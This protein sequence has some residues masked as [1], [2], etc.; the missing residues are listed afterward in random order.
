ML[1]LGGSL[2]EVKFVWEAGRF[3]QAYTMARAAALDPGA[4]PVLAS[5]FYSQVDDFMGRN[6]LGFGLHWASGQEVALRVLAWLFGLHVFSAFGPVPDSLS[7]AIGRHVA[8]SAAHI[9]GHIE[10][11]R[12]AVYNNHLL[13]EAL[14]LYAAGSLLRGSAAQRWRDTGF[15]ILVEQADRQVYADGASIQAS[16]NYQRVAMQLYAWATAFRR[17]GGEPVPREWT[18]AMERSLDFLVA[19]QNPDD[20]RLPNYGSNDGSNPIALASTDF[21]DFRPILQTLSVATRGERIYEAGAWDEM[22]AWLFG[23]E[24]LN[25]P[26]RIPNRTSV[27]FAATGYHVLRGKEP[28]SFCTFRCG[29]IRDRFSQIDMLHLDVWWRGENVL[30]D[31]GSYLYNGPRRWHNHFLRTESHNTVRID[32]HDQMLHI[33]QFKTLY[34]TEARLLKFEDRTEW[35]ICEG[36]HYGYRRVG[37]SVHRRSVL[38]AKADALWV[39]VDSIT[40]PGNHEARLHWLAGPY[41]YAFDEAAACLRLHTF[42]GPFSA[43]ILDAA[44]EPLRDADV[45]AGRQDGAP[46]GWLSRYYGEKIPA[47]S[48]AATQSGPLPITFVTLLGGGVPRAS[49]S[50]D[51]WSVATGDNLVRFRIEAGSFADVAVAPDRVPELRR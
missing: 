3:P 15:D 23:P 18:A 26:L 35:A 14:G 22:P 47:P 19:Q 50:G 2:G 45:A 44:G 48:F 42:R 40:G 7:E 28:D 46:R 34:P 43:T 11:A 49:V 27:S 25:L 20:G 13:T 31:G 6:P 21:S 1:R 51:A 16:H 9:A 38:F 29:T 36:E 10:Y 4:A 32:G 12:D 24:R 39:V 17:A 37:Q 41:D 33:R 5:A 30:V 8:E